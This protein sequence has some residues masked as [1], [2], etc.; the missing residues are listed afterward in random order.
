MDHD[1]LEILLYM[2]VGFDINSYVYLP[3][4]VSLQYYCQ[5]SMSFCCKIPFK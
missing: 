1:L 4:D 5:C 3:F 2:E